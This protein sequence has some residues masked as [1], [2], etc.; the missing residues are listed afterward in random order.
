MRKKREFLEGV[1]YHVTSRTNDKIRIFENKLGRKI[2]LMVLHDAKNKFRFRLANFCVMPT[3]IHL[4]IEPGEGTNLAMIMQWIKTR[5]ATRWNKIH[6]STDHVWGNRYFARK[7]K[8]PLDYYFIM[9]YIDNNPIEAGLAETPADWKAS[10]AYYKA[11]N[12]PG[13]VDISPTDRQPYIKLLSPIPPLVAHLLPPAQL[14]QTQQY[15]GVYADTVERLYKVVQDMP[16][17]GDTE[18]ERHPPAYLHYFTGTADYFICEY[19][20]KDTMFGKVRFSMYHPA[21]EQ[22]GEAVSD[23]LNQNGVAPVT[24]S[25]FDNGVRALALTARG[26]NEYQKFSLSSL[27]SNDFL[28]LD[29]SWATP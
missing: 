18:T 15:Y 3:H 12:L 23:Q 16:R 5:S 4:L 9:N 21:N 17:I 24:P 8:D 11:Y 6:G 28:Q 19:D 7:V 20:G 22:H 29:F 1:F 13:L 26:G 27:K 2:M 14:E 10:G 25:T